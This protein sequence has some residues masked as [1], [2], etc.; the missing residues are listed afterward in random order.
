MGKTQP[1]FKNIFNSIDKKTILQS[2]WV[3]PNWVKTP[4]YLINN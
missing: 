4:N 1:I 3:K 2:K